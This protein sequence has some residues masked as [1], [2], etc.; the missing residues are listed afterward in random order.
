M[1]RYMS[2]MLVLTAIFYNGCTESSQPKPKPKEKTEIVLLSEQVNELGVKDKQL[3]Y[4]SIQDDINRY[5]KEGDEAYENGYNYEAIKAYELV[6]FYEGYDFIPEKKLNSIKKIAK[7]KSKSHYKKA[8]KY[9][10]TD[11]K[12]AVVEFNAVMKN[13][14]E[15]KDTQK[16][17]AILNSN[18]DIIIYQNSLE[19]SLQTRVI[20]CSGSIDELKDI[21]SNLD[22]LLKYDHKNS[23]ALK[24]RN[25]LK[26]YN[27]VLVEG[28]VKLYDSGNNNKAKQR[29]E[30]I[31]VIYKNDVTSLKYLKKI[32]VEK[33]IQKNLKIAKNYLS[34][35]EYTYSIKY[36]K[37]V[38]V[39][40]SKNKKAIKIIDK[41]KKEARK[42]VVIL[43]N[44]GKKQYNN[45]E[46]DSSKKSFKKALKID[47][48]CNTALIY[49]KKIDRQ[50]QTIK[51]LQ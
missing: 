49:S 12:R 17:L 40:D 6:N 9:S 19:S 47:P 48:Y 33:S 43:V 7:K 3:I 16:Q 36:A 10:T 24:A 21:N 2:F 51:S 22:E 8:V 46:L 14:P 42:K 50:L 26:E 4:R 32:K 5:N 1:N 13:N 18:R 37:K 30:Q 34:K 38:L 35:K 44:Q 20:N 31:L 27:V 28:A 39:I 11:K 23:V 29:F 45:K 15:Y 25:M 41:A